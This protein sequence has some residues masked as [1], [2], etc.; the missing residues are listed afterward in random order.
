MHG[1]VCASGTPY[2]FIS[3]RVW[4]QL[5]AGKARVV[6]VASVKH[7]EVRIKDVRAFL[8]DWRKGYYEFTKLANV[9]FAYELQ[10]RLGLHGVTSVAA[11]P[12][13]VRSNIWSAS[14]MFKKG[15]YK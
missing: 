5:I 7:R 2:V 13:G 6:T 8:T 14:P 9:Y 3:V 12:G 1:R 10:R 15:L 4:L 11:D